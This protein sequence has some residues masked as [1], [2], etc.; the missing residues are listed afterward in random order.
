MVAFIPPHS[1]QSINEA[2]DASCESSTADSHQERRFATQR[3]VTA[4]LIMKIFFLPN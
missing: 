3:R 2:R 4:P 1:R